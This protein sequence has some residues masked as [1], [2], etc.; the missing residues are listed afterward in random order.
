MYKDW[1]PALSH[2]RSNFQLLDKEIPLNV[3][4]SYYVNLDLS[5]GI[6][7]LGNGTTV[8]IEELKS[9]RFQMFDG[10]AGL[11]YDH[12]RIA[13]DALANYH[14]LSV[15]YVRK[16]TNSDGIRTFPDS[17]DVFSQ[18]NNFVHPPD[19]YREIVMPAVIA[20]MRHIHQEEVFIK[21]V[22]FF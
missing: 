22:F 3:P 19:V 4:K 17:F 12:A 18:N 9:Q 2:S 6:G 21:L 14:A 5:E 11:D 7:R 10:S 1:L 16:S 8:V 15:A 13:M 20:A